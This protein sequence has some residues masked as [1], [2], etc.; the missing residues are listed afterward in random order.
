CAI[1]LVVA[2]VGT[3]LV[4]LGVSSYD[5]PETFLGTK[6]SEPLNRVLMT[7]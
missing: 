6:K 2:A 7:A 3:L 4:C 1:T 5:K